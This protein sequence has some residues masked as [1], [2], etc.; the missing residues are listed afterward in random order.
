MCGIIGLQG[1]RDF[2]FLHK[3]SQHYGLLSEFRGSKKLSFPPKKGWSPMKDSVI[4]QVNS[5]LS[6][7]YACTWQGEQQKG[8][9]HQ[10]IRVTL[11]NA[12]QVKISV[13]WQD[14]FAWPS[15]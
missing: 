15:L 6:N 14:I 9:W 12:L 11:G 5:G 8:Q 3:E 2:I 10:V 13:T 7:L 4:L 1:V